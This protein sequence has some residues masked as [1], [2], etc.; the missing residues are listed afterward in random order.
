MNCDRPRHP[1]SGYLDEFNCPILR[2]LISARYSARNC[3]TRVVSRSEAEVTFFNGG[4]RRCNS[5]QNVE[6]VAALSANKIDILS[7]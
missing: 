7:L 1:R 5:R 2:A 6:R 3:S 4:L